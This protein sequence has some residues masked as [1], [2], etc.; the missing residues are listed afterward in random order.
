MAATIHTLFPNAAAEPASSA[1]PPMAPVL[2]ELRDR[3]VALLEDITRSM[4][5]KAGETLAAMGETTAT[6]TERRQFIDALRVLRLDRTP[7]LRG[8]ADALLAG[9][10]PGSAGPT[11]SD[12]EELDV[13]SFDVSE[14]AEERI[15]SSCLARRLTTMY[16][17]Q[18][19]EL[20]RRVQLMRQR[21]LQV[22][23]R[24]MTPGR[25]AD[26]FSLATRQLKTEFQI[27]LIVYKLIERALARDLGKVYDQA[28][29]VLDRHGFGAPPPVAI[30]KPAAINTARPWE[31]LAPVSDPFAC[32]EAPKP[33]PASAARSLSDTLHALAATGSAAHG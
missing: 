26:A 29:A 22:P 17:P 28:F 4:L 13:P 7:F 1:P 3:C 5:D 20:D 21:G 16:R 8:H 24:L 15:A 31:A 6:E 33:T 14:E 12:A 18:L 23:V 11:T 19:T 9:F 25:L 30:V 2:A 10:D 27:K 32:L